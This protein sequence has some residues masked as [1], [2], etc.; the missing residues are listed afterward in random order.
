MLQKHVRIKLG[1]LGFFR[2]LINFYL[3]LFQR[4]KLLTVQLGYGQFVRYFG[5]KD[6]AQIPVKQVLKAFSLTLV[7]PLTRFLLSSPIQTI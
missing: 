1:V 4:A 7:L 3:W 6:T 2:C 5:C